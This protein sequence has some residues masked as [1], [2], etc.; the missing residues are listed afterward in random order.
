[1]ARDITGYFFFFVFRTDYIFRFVDGTRNPDHLLRALID[2]AVIFP[3]DDSRR[4]VAGSYVYAGKFVHNLQKFYQMDGQ[5]K[6]EIIG[7]KYDT[8]RFFQLFLA[9]REFFTRL[10]ILPHQVTLNLFV[11]IRARG[12]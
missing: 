3:S 12:V 5:E 7:R 1:M 2:Q 4:H 9:F 6:D 8:V 10:E 11:G